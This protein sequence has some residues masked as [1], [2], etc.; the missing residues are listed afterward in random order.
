MFVI[1]Y[2]HKVIPMGAGLGGGS[3]DAAFTLKLLNELF[4]I[5]LTQVQLSYYAGLLGSDVTFFL[6]NSVAIGTGKGNILEDCSLSLENYYLVLVFPEIHCSTISAYKKIKTD[7]NYNLK[8][9]LVKPILEW[10]NCIINTFEDC[11]FSTF[12][13]IKKI[14]DTLYDKGAVFSSLSGSGS[15]VFGIFEKEPDNI[16]SSFP[17]NYEVN[18]QKGR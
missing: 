14:K 16:K 9:N 6:K 4:L 8:R 2:L 12:P 7:P 10:E 1:I 3:S 18:I 17:K 5:G 13:E 15:T 11:I